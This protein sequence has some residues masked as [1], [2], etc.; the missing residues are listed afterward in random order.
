MVIQ[1]IFLRFRSESI[2]NLGPIFV[3]V[4]IPKT[5]FYNGYRNYYPGIGREGRDVVQTPLSS[6]EVREK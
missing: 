4:Y 1:K 3:T 2:H 5:F 6:A